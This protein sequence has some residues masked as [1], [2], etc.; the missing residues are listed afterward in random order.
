MSDDLLTDHVRQRIQERCDLDP[1]QLPALWRYGVQA[2]DDD[3]TRFRACP[4]LYSEYRVIVWQGRSYLLVLSQL[5][6][7][8]VTVMC[9]EER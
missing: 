7:K 3:L 2:T 4:H 1:D 9:L 6:G 5:S 8:F